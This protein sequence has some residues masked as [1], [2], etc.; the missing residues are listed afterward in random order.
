LLA[1]SPARY[2]V[3]QIV[4][5]KGVVASRQLAALSLKLRIE[6]ATQGAYPERLS[7][8]D[9]KT[10][11]PLVG[12]HPTYTR[13]ASGGVSLANPSAAAACGELGLWSVPPPFEWTLPPPAGTPR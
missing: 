9:A 4:H 7:G 2:W 11:D 13:T 6:A 5:Y 8:E 3:E 10:V 12:A 1:F